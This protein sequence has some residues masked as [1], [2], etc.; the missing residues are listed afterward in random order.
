MVF[1]SY[2]LFP[3]MSVLQNIVLAP[4]RVHRK[5]AAEARV[6]FIGRRNAEDFAE[7]RPPLIDDLRVLADAIAALSGGPAPRR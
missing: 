2:N 1:Q 5:A 4:T 6:A 7:P 3:H